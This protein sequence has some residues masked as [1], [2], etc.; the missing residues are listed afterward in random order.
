MLPADCRVCN[1]PKADVSEDGPPCAFLTGNCEVVQ[2]PALSDALHPAISNL[3]IQTKLIQPLQAI[4][5]T[6]C[7]RSLQNAVPWMCHVL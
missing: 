4:L 5:C 1:Q 7:P 6:R 3:F 2:A